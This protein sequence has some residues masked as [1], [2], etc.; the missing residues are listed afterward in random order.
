MHVKAMVILQGGSLL[1]E[2]RYVNN[3][4]FDSPEA[5]LDLA[6]AIIIG[7][8]RAFYE[9]IPAGRA[10][11][12]GA[13]ISPYVQRAY[14]VRFYNMADPEPRVPVI[15]TGTLPAVPS[16][17]E[18]LPEEVA[19]VH[20]FHGAPPVTGRRRGRNYLGPLNSSA[21]DGATTSA[22]TRV[23]A[24]FRGNVAAAALALA[25]AEV[26]W[27]VYS[28]VAN[29]LTP[30]VAGWVDNEFDTQRR[31]GAESNLRSTWALP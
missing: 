16:G 17:A 31:R 18:G 23:D 1:P 7:P 11:A 3:L 14:E 24:G 10:A 13:G 2:D 29:T 25:G 6:A 4:H 20:A 30:V 27:A 21:F 22:P 15:A 9:T 12:V 19:V 26:G 8:V 5:S 28:G